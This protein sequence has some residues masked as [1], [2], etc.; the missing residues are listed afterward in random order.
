M[1]IIENTFARANRLLLI[2][3]LSKTR[4]IGFDAATIRQCLPFNP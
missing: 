3:G 1:D 2:P 4:A